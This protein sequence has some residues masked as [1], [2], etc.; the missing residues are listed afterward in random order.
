MTRFIAL[1]L[2]DC[3]GADRSPGV[4]RGVKSEGARQRPAGNAESRSRVICGSRW[5][6]PASLWA[7]DQPRPDSEASPPVCVP[8]ARRRLNHNSSRAR[9]VTKS[10]QYG[11][12]H[13]GLQRIAALAWSRIA[14]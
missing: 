6:C 1:D 8:C 10:C 13:C 4:D 14:P 12:T 2:H 3:T 5:R 11:S 9:L 7:G